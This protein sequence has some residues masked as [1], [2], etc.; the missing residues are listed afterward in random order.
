MFGMSS[1]EFWEEDPQLYWAYRTFYLQKLKNDAETM[2]YEAWLQGSYTCMAVSVALNN[3][4]AKQ[5]VKYPDKP[6][7]A[8]EEKI[9]TELQEKLETIND[10]DIRQQTEF[11]FWARL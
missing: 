11:N 3:A 2:N 4:F 1:K 5:K 7:G 6:M 10:K 9:K 8:E